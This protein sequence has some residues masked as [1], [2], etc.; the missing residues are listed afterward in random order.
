[1][2]KPIEVLASGE[3]DAVSAIRSRRV[4]LAGEAVFASLQPVVQNGFAQQAQVEA[5]RGVLAQFAKKTPRVHLAVDERLFEARK[6][7]FALAME[8]YVAWGLG[9]RG[10]GTTI[11]LGGAESADATHLSVVVFADGAVVEVDEKV[12][13]AAGASYFRDALT[14]MLGE[15]RARYPTAKLC[16]AAPLH[17]WGMP[18]V[19]FVGDKA[20]RG[21]SFRPLTRAKGYA[22]VYLAPA[23][24]AVLGVVFYAGAVGFGWSK[25]DGAVGEYDRAIS[26][27]TI[28]NQGGID[29]TFLDVV[30]ARRLYMEEPRRQVILAAK[31]EA[32]VRGVGAVPGVQILE[33]RLPAP[34]INP[35]NQVGVTISPQEARMRQAITPER[36]PDVW[37]S[38]AVPKS[39]DAAINQARDVMLLIANS[40]GMSLRLAHQGWRDEQK[41]RVYNI[42]GFMHNT[43]GAHS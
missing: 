32:L 42:E 29:T 9:R 13:P 12:L 31:A 33:L 10:K 6:V 30:N 24:V 2:A 8:A 19:E 1:M 20:L 21:L 16:Q 34:S 27:P 39:D 36:T 35:Q 26:D 4:V 41:R 38:V 18:D 11:L 5:R 15:L 22:G 37:I 7:R 40:T 17:E 3:P 43:E 23:A 14:A 25:Y 28:K